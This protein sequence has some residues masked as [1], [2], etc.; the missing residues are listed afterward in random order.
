M[1]RATLLLFV[2]FSVWGR[3]QEHAWV[4]FKD[5]DR[6]E[7]S[8]LNPSSILSARAIQKKGRF[9]IAIDERDVPVSEAYIAQ[10][11]LQTGITV[12]AKSKWFNCVHVLGNVS[13]I[14]SL[15]D[16]PFVD[17]ISYADKGINAKSDPGIHMADQINNHINKFLEQGA[18]FVYGQSEVQLQQ[19]GVP[20]LHQ[21]NY[22]GDGL[23]I[24]VLDSGFPY[25][26]QME[27]FGRLRMNNDL[28]GGYD[29]VVRST[30]I[31]ATNGND[32]GTRVLSDM[33][34]FVDGQFVGAA[35]DASYL[36]FRTE[37]AVTETPVE[38]SY[39]VEAAERADSL[40]VD[41]INSSLGYSTYDDPRYNYSP[42]DMDGNTAFISRGANIATE[43]GILVV[44]SAGNSGDSSWGI[45]T[46]PAD[47]DV[48]GVGAVD[49]AGNYVAFSSRGPSADGRFK[50]DGMALGAGAA[51]IGPDGRLVKNNGTSFASPLMAG[52]IASLWQAFPEKNNMEIMAMVR[53]SSSR[54]QNPNAEM[55]Y[56]IPN[57]S[58]PLAKLGIDISNLGDDLY[59]FPNPSSTEFQVLLPETYGS[60]HLMLFDTYGKRILE[61]RLNQANEEVSVEN[62][63]RAMY[64]VH[65]NVDGV[66]KEFKLIKN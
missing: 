40:G 60:A 4:Y 6:V 43:K 54:Y 17:H 51:V 18:D 8:L 34:G 41:I 44:N 21:N 20:V 16:L 46:A 33:A 31:Y 9:N 65:V 37:D 27:A 2:I 23:L 19:L 11:K 38:E 3:A 22:T 12:K 14:A 29:F 64:I 61:R 66:R 7:E 55:G 48:F 39:W 13:D 56:G 32:H 42:V 49:T 10:L 28:W 45:I 1:A 26:D 25:V 47:A 30:N 58:I 24:A 63:S 15:M 52:A 36:L 50:P 5:K 57:F 35:P 62:L 53:E 59:L